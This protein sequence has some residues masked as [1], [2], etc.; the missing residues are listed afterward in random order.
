MS[1]VILPVCKNGQQR[2]YGV[3]RGEPARVLCELEAN[4]MDIHFTWKFN[5]TSDAVDL[6]VSLVAADRSRSIATYTPMTELDY[7]TLLCW[8]RNELGVQ[9]E[10]CVYTISPAVRSHFF[11]ASP[12]V[13]DRRGWGWVGDEPARKGTLTT[14]KKKKTTDVGKGWLKKKNELPGAFG[15][16]LHQRRK[17]TRVADKN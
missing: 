3:A 16:T 14:K 2:A 9:H 6:P 1:L 4:P 7:G 8:G 15:I 5:N 11:D 10:P 13:E 17:K 12:P